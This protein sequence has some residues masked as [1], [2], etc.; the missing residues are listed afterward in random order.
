M[1]NFQVHF[2]III[3]LLS[4]KFTWNYRKCGMHFYWR[5][6]TVN[7]F[8]FGLEMEDFVLTMLLYQTVQ[9]PT[10]ELPQN[11]YQ[12][13]ILIKT[14]VSFPESSTNW[15]MCH[16]NQHFSFASNSIHC[17]IYWSIHSSLVVAKSNLSFDE[18]WKFY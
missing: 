10:K 15:I 17:F 6:L 4:V 18:R 13:K 2:F 12:I 14:N 3:I 16:H 1:R 9:H 11:R 8:Y 5:F 7:S